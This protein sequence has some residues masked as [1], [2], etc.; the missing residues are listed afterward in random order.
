MMFPIFSGHERPTNAWL[1][2]SAPM[3]AINALNAITAPS[4]TAPRSA[5]RAVEAPRASGGKGMRN[6]RTSPTAIASTATC[7]M[8]TTL[9]PRKVSFRQ[10]VAPGVNTALTI[11]PTMLNPSAPSRI[12]AVVSNGVRQVATTPAPA[13]CPASTSAI[14][15]PQVPRR[16]RAFES[17]RLRKLLAPCGVREGRQH[18]RPAISDEQRVGAEDTV[19]LELELNDH[20]RIERG[21]VLQRLGAEAD[22][23]DGR[24]RRRSKVADPDARAA[25]VD[26]RRPLRDPAR[27][28]ITVFGGR[29]PAPR[30][31]RQRSSPPVE[32]HAPAHG[33]E[34][35][36]GDHAVGGE[37]A[38]RPVVVDDTERAF[39]CGGGRPEYAHPLFERTL[40]L[41]LAHTGLQCVD[42]CSERVLGHRDRSADA[43]DL[44][45]ALDPARRAHHRLAVGE[46]RAW[47]R[48]CEQLLEQ[49]G[50][51]VDADAPGIRDAGNGIDGAH[52]VHRVPAHRV[53]ARGWDPVGYAEVGD[54]HQ[55][56]LSGL[57]HD[58]A[59]RRERAGAREPEARGPG[60]ETGVAFA[61]E[62]EPVD[63]LPRHLVERA[64][65]PLSHAGR[66]R[67]RSGART[68][69]R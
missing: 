45:G 14:E 36:V 38:D 13:P 43:L 40:E 33:D 68:R 52:D 51:P 6:A 44:A 56:D 66:H 62:Q 49:R 16:S 67:T 31:A 12:S 48:R 24:G 64:R 53:Q 17:T 26:E 20:S 35:A 65:A 7:Q 28:P 29:R 41:H 30:G 2:P 19:G 69:R 60:H 47:E 21:A 46:V 27:P 9:N 8:L 5:A 50:E 34:V 22:A 63:V 4:T 23:A 18:F 54:A 32:Q 55:V 37:T 58:D 3:Q 11:P 25:P 15:P 61:P 57:A 10:A 1:S 59:A 42:G 39:E